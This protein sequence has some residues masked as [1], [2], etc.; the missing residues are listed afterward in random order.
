MRYWLTLASIVLA[1][2]AIVVCLLFKFHEPHRRY[3]RIKGGMAREEVKSVM[4]RPCDWQQDDTFAEQ[5][6]F[7]A[8]REVYVRYNSEMR[9]V[10]KL[11][12]HPR[13]FALRH[14]ENVIEAADY[15]S[16]F[17]P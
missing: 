4:G 2:L 3:A 11:L 17:P 6:H 16:Q 1:V 13:H 15:S 12:L 5:W 7:P 8:N 9:V 10:E 14:P